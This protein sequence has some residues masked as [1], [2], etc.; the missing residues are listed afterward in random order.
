MGLCRLPRTVCERV[1][2]RWRDGSGSL[3]ILGFP[4]TKMLAH[5]LARAVDAADF[6][7]SRNGDGTVPA[8]AH[9]L[10]ACRAAMARRRGQFA[11]LGVSGHT[12]ACAHGGAG[13]RRGRFSTVEKRFRCCE[14]IS[15]SH[16]AAAQTVCLPRV[17]GHS[18]ACT[19]VGEV[20]R[21]DRCSTVEKRRRD[22]ARGRAQSARVSASDGATRQAVCLPL[23]S[24]HTEAC[25]HVGEV[26]R[27][28]RCSTVEKQWRE[29]SRWT[30]RRR[31]VCACLLCA[32]EYRFERQAKCGKGEM[33]LQSGGYRRMSSAGDCDS[34]YCRCEL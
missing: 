33:W 10:R 21:W 27:W 19:H 30:P 20:G 8:A 26:G 14:N 29:S 3:Q 9:S 17:S 24:G 11:D 28:E 5:T 18:E 4:V 22:C 34:C 7:P 2:E 12:N 23:V 16:G 1:G 15:A 32:L 13:G 6:R 31:C 25:T